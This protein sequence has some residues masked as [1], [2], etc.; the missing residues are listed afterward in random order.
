MITN[1]AIKLFALRI[2]FA[3]IFFSSPIGWNFMKNRLQRSDKLRLFGAYFWAVVLAIYTLLEISLLLP[4]LR[5]SKGSSRNILFLLVDI[6]HSGINQIS[7]IISFLLIFKRDAI[8]AWFNGMLDLDAVLQTN[9][10]WHIVV[11]VA[12]NWSMFTGMLPGFGLLLFEEIEPTHRFLEALFGIKP[13]MELKFLPLW[14]TFMLFLLNVL[15]PLSTIILT[16]FIYLLSSYVWL[17]MIT[18]TDRQLDEVRIIHGARRE[19]VDAFGDLQILQKI[20]NRRINLTEF[21]LNTPLGRVPWSQLIS[22][23]RYQQVLNSM[24]N[25]MVQ[26]I[27]MGSHLGY[28]LM[29]LTSSLYLSIRHSGSIAFPSFLVCPVLVIAV[30][31]L[32]VVECTIVGNL[33]EVSV[34]FTKKLSRSRSG[35][36]G[37]AFR[38]ICKSLRPIKLELASPFFFV[39]KGLIFTS[40]D[41]VLNFVIEL[42][43]IHQ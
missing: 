29:I 32:L 36:S 25:G 19:I 28:I 6:L 18:P 10:I 20:R 23:Y 21:D 37:G 16:L 13:K 39:D 43:C 33:Y 4:K 5:T 34:S 30:V 8:I 40:V 31:I 12:W 15:T 35:V 38:K 17:V 2:R 41:Q 42:L 7:T 9:N 14:L 1:I 24:V 11:P 26:N 22:Y 27:W 3:E